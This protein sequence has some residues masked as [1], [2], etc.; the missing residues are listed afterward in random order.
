MA[1]G[2]VGEVGQV[3]M[4]PINVAEEHKE[5]SAIAGK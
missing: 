1:V 4:W 5:E 3:V 2:V